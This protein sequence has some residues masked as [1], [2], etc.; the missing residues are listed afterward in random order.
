M[1]FFDGVELENIEEKKKKNSAENFEENVSADLMDELLSDFNPMEDSEESEEDVNEMEID[2]PFS[3]E[4][5]VPIKTSDEDDEDEDFD[6]II[7]TENKPV[8]S[9]K[10]Q[11]KEKPKKKESDE[12][13]KTE[14]VNKVE[15][16]EVKESKEEKSMSATQENVL[17][18]GTVI[19]GDFTAEQNV[20]VYGKIVGNLTTSGNVYINHGAVVSGFVKANRITVEGYVE[21]GLNGTD[22]LITGP[23]KIK[24]GI[25][26][27][28]GN[29]TISNGSIVIG[30][31]VSE[32]GSVNIAGAVKGNIDAKE[33]VT[34]YESAIIQGNIHSAQIAIE[35]GAALDGTCTQDYAKVKPSDFFANVE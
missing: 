28:N 22:I 34:V 32:S 12:T 1:G 30:D 9:S 3:S 16:K 19:T 14:K 23:C 26:A 24:G 2:L 27:S 33:M 31:I 8:A 5:A 21:N 15:K 29:I 7:P 11:E 25:K 10:P 17:L 18:S 4:E 35:P 6:D 20:A 13:S